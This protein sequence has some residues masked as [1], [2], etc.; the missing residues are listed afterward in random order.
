MCNPKVD[1]LS[2]MTYLSRFPHAKLK[3]GAPV[4]I[5]PNAAR[6]RAYGPGTDNTSCQSTHHAHS[7]LLI[8]TPTSRH[9]DTC[10]MLLIAVSFNILPDV[11]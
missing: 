3:P 2:M 1:E 10:W 9:R 4:Q 7:A 6:V 5:K 8:A 11:R